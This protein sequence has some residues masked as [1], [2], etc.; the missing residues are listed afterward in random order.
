MAGTS[1][2]NRILQKPGLDITIC[3][4][5]ELGFLEFYQLRETLIESKT[6]LFEKGFF[7]IRQ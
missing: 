5:G 7:T 4:N 6:L 2:A 1:L 3:K